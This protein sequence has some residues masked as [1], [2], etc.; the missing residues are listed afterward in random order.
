MDTS[1]DPSEGPDQLQLLLRNIQSSLDGQA[2]TK[3]SISREGGQKNFL[4]QVSAPLP[5]PLRP[6]DWPVHLLPASQEILTAEFVIPCLTQ[7][8]IAKTE[9]S[10]LL[11]NVKDK[12]H[13]INRLMGKLQSAGIDVSTVFPGL[14]SSKSR[15]NL[16][17]RDA[18]GDS[19][20]GLREFNEQEWRKSLSISAGALGS[21]DTLIREAFSSNPTAL[22]NDTQ[23]SQDK[24][25]WNHLE[26]GEKS[27]VVVDLGSS[28]L[29]SGLHYPGEMPSDHDSRVGR[30]CIQRTWNSPAN[31]I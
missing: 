25:W 27:R 2:G 10:S 26:I 30:D 19:V 16:A 31:S 29:K 9:I 24:A 23:T 7:Q 4:L 17:T 11:L 12:D 8:V 20:K 22:P 14:I 1:I 28:S 13:I 18:A 21:L 3:L 6:L 15:K 5:V